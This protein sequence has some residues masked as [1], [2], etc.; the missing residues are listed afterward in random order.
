[1][2]VESL[3][4]RILSFGICLS[5]ESLQCKKESKILGDKI[6]AVRIKKSR[7]VKTN[8]THVLTELTDGLV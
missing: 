5:K 3:V 7:I 1:M 8:V 6:V 2:H 4:F